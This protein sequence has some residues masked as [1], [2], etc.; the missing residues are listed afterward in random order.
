MHEV[1]PIAQDERFKGGIHGVLLGCVL[2]VLA[3][4]LIRRNRLNTGIYTA[5]VGF[6]LWHIIGHYLVARDQVK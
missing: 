1:T 5:L 2:P 4:N 3:F 6:E